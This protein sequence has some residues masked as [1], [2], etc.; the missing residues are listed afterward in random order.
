MLKIRIPFGFKTFQ[1]DNH[2]YVFTGKI[3]LKIDDLTGSQV[4]PN[5]T[6][7]KTRS[8]YW[9]MSWCTTDATIH[10]QNVTHLNTMIGN[11]LLRRIRNKY[12]LEPVEFEI[13]DLP[14]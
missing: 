12:N 2:L 5:I 14:Y 8:G 10:Q 4:S 9:L 1:F 6:Y 7:Q 3:R 11:T 13:N